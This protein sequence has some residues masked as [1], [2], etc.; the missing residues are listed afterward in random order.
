MVEAR[1]P[2]TVGLLFSSSGAG[3]RR[4]QNYINTIP[5]PAFPLKGKESDF[6]PFKGRIEVGMVSQA[7]RESPGIHEGVRSHHRAH[8]L[9]AKNDS[10]MDHLR[11][12][13]PVV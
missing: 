6:L 3:Y 13:S 11:L 12:P 9:N 10:V 5:I 2:Q 7:H 4:Y 1:R 8:Y